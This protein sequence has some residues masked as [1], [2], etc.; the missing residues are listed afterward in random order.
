MQNHVNF[1]NHLVKTILILMTLH[2][3][4]MAISW[5]HQKEANLGNLVFRNEYSKI[6]ILQLDK[7]VELMWIKFCK[8]GKH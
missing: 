8:I 5:V 7:K 3:H 6:Q 1:L 2:T 4:M